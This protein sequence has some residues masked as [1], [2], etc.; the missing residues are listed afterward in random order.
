VA[1]G[2]GMGESVKYQYAS[3]PLW[4]YTVAKVSVYIDDRVWAR[5]REAVFRKH[6]SLRQLSS[7]TEALMEDFAVEDAMLAAFRRMNV[8]VDGTTSSR[9]VK[10]GRPSL[11]GPPSEDIIRDMRRKRIAQALP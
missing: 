10:E 6:G 3:K 1:A 2:V 4:W 5:F 9:D 11:K 7:E 8:T